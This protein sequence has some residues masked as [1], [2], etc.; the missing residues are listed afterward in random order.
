MKV[1]HHFMC[2][3]CVK[4]GQQFTK[5]THRRHIKSRATFGFTLI[6]V[7]IAM[8]IL[9]GA[10]IILY[11]SWNSSLLAVRKGRNYNTVTLLLQKRVVEFEIE[12]KDKRVE[13]ILEDQSGDFGD[14]YPEYKWE[15]KLKPFAVPPILPQNEDGSQNELVATIV[16]TMTDYFKK[17]VREV[18]VTVIYKKGD[19]P[20]RYSLSTIFVDFTKDL[21]LGF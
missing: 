3:A 10:S 6:E 18:Q 15:I 1:A 21:P 5:M 13:E 14:A 20:I 7:L 9:A 17:A 11:Q 2:R 19:K 16:K 4:I 8:L 12:T